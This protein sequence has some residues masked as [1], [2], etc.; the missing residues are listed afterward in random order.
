MGAIFNLK[1]IAIIIN[2][3]CVFV[4]VHA[5]KKGPCHNRHQFFEAAVEAAATTSYTSSSSAT[6]VRSSKESVVGRRSMQPDINNY[7]IDL[8]QPQKAK[9]AGEN[10]SSNPSY[11]LLANS[12]FG[13]SSS[14]LIQF[15][16]VSSI[17]SHPPLHI[18]TR[19]RLER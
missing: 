11:L 3:Y 15:F 5:I 19:N 17:G 1:T 18:C 7:C 16:N 8:L 14:K 2:D 12:S 4:L 13:T 6:S 9:A 10:L